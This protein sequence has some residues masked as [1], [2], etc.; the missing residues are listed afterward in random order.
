MREGWNWGIVGVGRDCCG[1]DVIGDTNGEGRPGDSEGAVG[2]VM[3]RRGFCVLKLASLES[4]ASA[5]L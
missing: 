3:E 2:A 5:E 1:I 4:A